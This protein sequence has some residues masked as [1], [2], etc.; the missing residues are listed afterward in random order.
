M[1]PRIVLLHA[2]ADGSTTGIADRIGEVLERAGCTVHGRRLDEGAP[3][4]PVEL[5]HADAV[6]VGSAVHDMAW[7]PPALA[8]LRDLA[9]LDPPPP[10]W[11]FSV[12]GVQ[13]HGPLTRALA[14]QEVRRVERGFPAGLRP[15]DHRLFGGIV[16]FAG[17][18][19]WG[20]LFYRFVA[21]GRPGDH[22]D[23]AAVEAWA[24]T[25]ATAPAA[26]PSPGDGPA[27]RP[28]PGAR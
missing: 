21:G 9:A 1:A 23:W 27:A 12:G 6:V 25:V 8:A 5:A 10:L 3:A 17:L 4:D 20:R 22:R 28:R 7:L 26:S 24:G 13:P 18:P 16:R 11:C 19:L 15:R 14:A 2:T